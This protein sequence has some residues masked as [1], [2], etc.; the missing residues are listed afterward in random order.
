VRYLVIPMQPESSRG[1][2]EAQLRD[3]VTR[4]SMIGTGLP[5]APSSALA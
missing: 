3:W 1:L 4:D 5:E 2:E